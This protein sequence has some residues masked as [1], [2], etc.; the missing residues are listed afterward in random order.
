MSDATSEPQGERSIADLERE[1]RERKLTL[2]N[3][4][5]PAALEQPQLLLEDVRAF[6]RRFRG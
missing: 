1:L 5:W 2:R 6:I 4:R 3:T